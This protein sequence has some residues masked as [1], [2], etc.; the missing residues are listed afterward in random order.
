MRERNREREGERE[1]KWE[2]DNEREQ[3][4]E[5]KS[6]PDLCTMCQEKCQYMTLALTEDQE[7]RKRYRREDSLVSA[8]GGSQEI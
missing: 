1:K 6:K 7:R 2:G 5:R 4:K 8:L 3:R